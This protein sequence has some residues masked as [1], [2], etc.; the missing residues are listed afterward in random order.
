MAFL[1]LQMLHG[2]SG[3]EL[4]QAKSA[5]WISLAQANSTVTEITTTTITSTEVSPFTV[6]TL[7]TNSTTTAITLTATSLETQTL[8]MLTSVTQSIY[9]F[10]TIVAGTT[11]TTTMSSFALT[12]DYLF[13]VWLGTVVTVAYITYSRLKIAEIWV[14]IIV[15][16]ITGLFV[17]PHIADE[18][19]I[20]AAGA[21]LAG[22][23]MG[24]LAREAFS[25]WRRS[26]ERVAPLHGNPSP[27]A[28]GEQGEQLFE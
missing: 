23:I 10:W 4:E 9:G 1:G 14:A 2:A 6:Y 25:R 22:T 20:Q 27:S 13:L 24:A 5:A 17:T 16:A 28:S 19:R 3:T 15:A 26:Q 12:L 18:T 7:V 8:T 21:V 11:V